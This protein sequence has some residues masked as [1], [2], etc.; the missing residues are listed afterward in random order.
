M[1]PAE[2]SDEHLV[3]QVLR[4][5]QMAFKT[6]MD[7]YQERLHRFAVQYTREADEAEDIVQDAFIRV[8][9]NLRT[10]NPQLKFS[11]WI[12]RITR[13]LALNA[14]RSRKRLV[15]GSAADALLNRVADP[16]NI[17]KEAE[18]RELAEILRTSVG[19][20]PM[21][22]REPITLFFLEEKSYREISDILRLPEGTI[23][24]RISRGKTILRTE[25]DHKL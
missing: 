22:Y 6:L 4:G 15:N 11:S 7:R 2:P 19:Q 8:Y 25:V 14:I 12:Y 9:R 24:T 5:R 20:L 13:N 17:H 21:K 18:D 3:S 10:F 23:A 16:H 1:T